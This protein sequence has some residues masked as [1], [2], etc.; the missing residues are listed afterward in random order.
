MLLLGAS[1][2]IDFNEVATTG[3]N[4]LVIMPSP[5]D[6]EQQISAKLIELNSD[7]IG[8]KVVKSRY[9]QRATHHLTSVLDILDS[10]KTSAGNIEP[11]K[12]INKAGNTIAQ[13]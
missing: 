8:E 11:V 7:E 5:T 1:V 10:I 3:E 4:N 2:S 6:G 9:N 13:W 12:A